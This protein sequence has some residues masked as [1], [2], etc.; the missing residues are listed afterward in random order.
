MT[1]VCS[2]RADAVMR[3]DFIT[4]CVIRTRIPH[5]RAHQLTCATDSAA[6]LFVVIHVL[7]SIGKHNEAVYDDRLLNDLV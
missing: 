5:A 1:Q 2:R 6:N 4:V 7:N 3:D